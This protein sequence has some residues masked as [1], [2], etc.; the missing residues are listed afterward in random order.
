MNPSPL[1][2]LITLTKGV[3]PNEAAGGGG[4]GGG[5][6]HKGKKES[7]EE[8]RSTRERRENGFTIGKEQMTF[9]RVMVYRK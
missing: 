2:C 3:S 4:G 5:K 1:I 9:K 6:A 7:S 8:R